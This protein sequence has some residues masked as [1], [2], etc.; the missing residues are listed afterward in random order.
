MNLIRSVLTVCVG[1]ALL[2]CAAGVPDVVERSTPEAAVQS[3]AD[4]QALYASLPAAGGQVFTLDPIRSSIRIHAFRAARGKVFGHNHVLSAPTFV[5]YYFESPQGLAASR[6]DLVF[7]LDELAFDDPQQ[8]L[9]LGGAFATELTPDAVASTREHM[10]GANNFQAQQFPR[11]RI[12]SVELAG[13]LP[14]VAA[15]ISVELHGQARE[16]WVPLTVTGPPQYLQVQGSMVLRQTDFGVRP[17]SVLGGL[18]AV[19][20]AVVVDFTLHGVDLR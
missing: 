16:M 1:L 11:V 19:Q 7:R 5:G 15:L 17:Y 8:R 14:K 10:L 4:L 3:R 2:G 9:A 13:E 6:F 18:L 12:R 20:D